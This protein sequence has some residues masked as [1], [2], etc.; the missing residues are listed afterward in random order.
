MRSLLVLVLLLWSCSPEPAPTPAPPPAPAPVQLVDVAA[1]SGLH[2]TQVS[3]ASPHKYFP[4]TMG[5]GGAFLDYDGDGDLDI[6]AI[7]GAWIEDPPPGPPPVDA[8]FR[9]DGNTGFIE[10]GVQAG[11]AHPGFG[12]GCAVG[13][14]DNDGDAD[15][16]LSNY[17]PNALFRNEGKGRFAELGARAGV[18][19]PRWGTS[20][21]FGDYDRD[22]D[23]DLFV[24]NY[25]EYR[26]E[27]Q[28][29]D[30]APYMVQTDQTDT[31]A[32]KGYPHPANFRGTANILY[33][34]EG[35]DRFA[36]LTR[37][38][39]LYTEEG[40]GLG[41]VFL[42]YDGDGWPDLYVANDGV[43]N[44][45]Y[46][47]RGQGVFE[48]RAAE[49]GVAYGQDGQM[50]AGMGVDAG[51]YDNDGRQDLTVTN[52]Q[53]EPNALYRNQGK[54]YFAN[55]TY[56]SGVGL[57]SLPFLGFGTQFLDCDNDGWLDLFVANGH[58]LDNVALFD[59]STT[60][61]Q[62]PLLFHNQ[63]FNP[64][65][66][67][68]FAEVGLQVGMQAAGVGR[69]SAAGDY[70]DDGDLDLLVFNLGQPL[71]LL[72]NE[73]RGDRHWLSLRT[74]GVQSNRDGIGAQVKVVAGD[75]VQVQEVRAGRSYLS[76][77]DLRLH[78]GLGARTRVDQL[79]IRWPSGQVQ[80]FTDLGTDQFLVVQEGGGMKAAGR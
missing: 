9:N 15:L 75:L 77:S 22:G 60:Y 36:D 34:N 43:R 58:V 14:Y 32:A 42:D 25:V 37:Q 30:A 6:F 59:Q 38:A 46:H 5:G 18:D 45:L 68:A 8:L 35:G 33:R 44:Y 11:V 76:S 57:V 4:E 61:A 52:F 7:N 2:F 20:C 39:G 49:A 47:N 80:Q 78:F 70:D 56:A 67:I 50:E 1:Q 79:E 10:V 51:D 29:E 26:P 3:G 17:G 21:A 62:R 66:K 71:V 74:A 16:Y 69:G 13:D 28:R 64:Q 63:G 54:G 31:A 24:A 40:K 55:E 65:G 72:R 19:D 12:M 53:A 27:L 73:G 23:V 41:V 48:E